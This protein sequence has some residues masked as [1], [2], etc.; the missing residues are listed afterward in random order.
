VILKILKK[1]SR[2][3][4]KVF[5]QIHIAGGLEGG[6][7]PLIAKQNYSPQTRTTA[8]GQRESGTYP[9]AA[10]HSMG[11]Q[12]I[13]RHGIHVEIAS[14]SRDLI[15]PPKK[16]I[17]YLKTKS[18]EATP[19]HKKMLQNVMRSRR[20][21][22]RYSSVLNYMYPNPAAFITFTYK[23]EH[24]TTEFSKAFSDWNKFTARL[25]KQYPDVA[26]IRVAERHEKGDIH[27]HAIVWGLPPEM[28]CNI[29]KKKQH[30]CTKEQRRWC[31][32]GGKEETS[33]N[34]KIAK[35]W[36]L[37]YVD[38]G[39]VRHPDRVGAY[40]G[41]YLTKKDGL[42]DWRAFGRQMVSTNSVVHKKLALARDLGV[43]SEVT[44]YKHGED[45]TKAAVDLLKQNAVVTRADTQFETHWLGTCT[46]SRLQLSRDFRTT[47]EYWLNFVEEG[48]SMESL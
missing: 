24:Q 44:T 12:K 34:R 48:G 16:R 29:G 19:E 14:Y 47:Q 23:P 31:E 21:I 39:R 5:Q 13:L 18:T 8:K 41:K 7:S 37:G 3:L 27:I 6:I 9:A 45:A 43:Y 28:V 38:V 40:I 2:S 17:I 10:P 33:N 35:L 26:I 1:I 11:Y 36:Q 32:R 22:R 46:Y 4:N 15:R 20:T 42:Q 30:F 25:T